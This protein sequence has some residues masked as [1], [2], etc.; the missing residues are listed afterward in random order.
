MR[1]ARREYINSL[2]DKIR[3]YFSNNFPVDLKEIVR[4]LGGNLAITSLNYLNI[5]DDEYSEAFIT[6]DVEKPFEFRIV[7]DESVHRNRQNFSIAH[8]LGHL[9]LHLGYFLDDDKWRESKLK[10]ASHYRKGYGPDE[11][12]ANEFAAAFLMPK[13]EYLS[14]IYD[15][16]EI[17][18]IA[19]YF[20]VSVEAAINRGRFLNV[21]ARV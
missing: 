10:L 9:F 19:E 12:E 16:L 2:A 3:S 18:Q 17:E 4:K 20:G 1:Q 11:L 15:G 13:D 5:E 7:V 6:A 21:F 8:E 14:K